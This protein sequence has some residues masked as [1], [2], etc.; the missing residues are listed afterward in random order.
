MMGLNSVSTLR[1]PSVLTLENIIRCRERERAERLSE[2]Q[3]VVI[4]RN[5]VRERPRGQRERER[6]NLHGRVNQSVG[7]MRDR[8][9]SEQEPG[10]A[11]LR[12]IY[13]DQLSPVLREESQSQID[14][15]FKSNK[16]QKEEEEK[17]PIS[18][19]QDHQNRRGVQVHAKR[20]KEKKKK[21]AQ[22]SIRPPPMQIVVSR[23]GR[24]A[25]SVQPERE[26]ERRA[27][28]LCISIT[29]N[30]LCIYYSYVRSVCI[31]IRAKGGGNI[32]TRSSDRVG[33]YSIPLQTCGSSLRG[34]SSLQ[35]RDLFL[36]IGPPPPATDLA[37][38]CRPSTTSRAV[39]PSRVSLHD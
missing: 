27:T 30:T 26:R 12:R 34:V 19:I 37:V 38:P 18:P 36:Q 14:F 8:H 7:W 24:S 28:E 32:G 9:R 2:R 5:G 6:R 15:E 25:S 4:I 1:G 11:A 39:I 21:R 3:R 13:D 33:Y 17:E 16:L 29:I 20:K 22:A 31:Y 23:L 35:E 10:S